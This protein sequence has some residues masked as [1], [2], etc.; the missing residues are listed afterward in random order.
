MLPIALLSVVPTGLWTDAPP[1]SSASCVQSQ[2]RL[3]R[4][5]NVRADGEEEEDAGGCESTSLGE[6][7]GC[8][9]GVPMAGGTREALGMELSTC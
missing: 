5:C 6:V 8:I 9:S 1:T 7:T 3:L 4:R 2:G